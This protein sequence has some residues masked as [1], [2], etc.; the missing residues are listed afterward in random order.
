MET[1]PPWLYMIIV[2]AALGGYWYFSQGRHGKDLFRNQFELDPDE[3]MTPPYPF[4]GQYKIE[5]SLGKDI[6]NGLMGLNE[7]GAFFTLALTSKGRLILRENEGAIDQLKNSLR[8][9]KRQNI[10]NIELRGD[11]KGKAVSVHGTKE[12]KVFITI[13]L[14]DG[15]FVPIVVGESVYNEMKKWLAH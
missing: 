9:Y 14:N 13:N 12:K 5:T 15:K 8:I 1:I 11:E 6:A 4:S 2:F 7:R 3:Q 10:L